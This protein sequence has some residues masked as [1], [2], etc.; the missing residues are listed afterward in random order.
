MRKR[1][2]FLNQSREKYTIACQK[3]QAFFISV[4]GIFYSVGTTYFFLSRWP[5]WALSWLNLGI[6]GSG[7]GRKLNPT[8]PAKSWQ[9]PQFVVVFIIVSGISQ[10][11]FRHDL[12]IFSFF[13]VSQFSISE[14]SRVFLNVLLRFSL[15]AIV[16]HCTVTVLIFWNSISLLIILLNSRIV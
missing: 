5:W 11:S 2:H 12:T 13:A 9:K 4:S 6:L 15:K 7:G 10:F 16:L 14:L 8:T 1:A 3:T